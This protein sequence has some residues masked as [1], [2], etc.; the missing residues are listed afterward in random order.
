MGQTWPVTT[1]E[2]QWRT[3]PPSLAAEAAAN[4]G[5]WVYE[6]DQDWLDDPNGDVPPE[7]VRGGWRVDDSGKA[8]GEYVP[9][10]R[11][12]PPQDDFSPLIEADH[13][14]EWLGD[15]P[16]KTVR[17]S[18]E[19]SLAGQVEGAT[20]EW[21]RITAEPRFLTGGTKIPDDPAKIRIVRTAL[22]VEFILLVTQP[23]QTGK[24]RLLRKEA[25]ARRDVLRGVFSL[26]VTG[27]D[28]PTGRERSWLDL[29]AGMDQ[30]GPLLDE[31]LYSVDQDD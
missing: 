19:L 3:P 5:G 24:R 28:E 29:G 31:R 22:A 20:V 2:S 6:I 9:N 13:W 7:A 18:I 14:L 21:L 8:T 4:P 23:G 16:A 11:H 10:H 30:V 15:D 27:M 12:V 25:P 1:P 17:D 26:A